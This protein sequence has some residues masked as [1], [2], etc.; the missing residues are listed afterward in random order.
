[1][2]KNDKDK[3]I[4]KSVFENNDALLKLIRALFMGL[5]L[6]PAEQKIIKDTFGGKTE[7]LEAMRRKFKPDLDRDASI[8]EIIHDWAGAENNVYGKHPDEIRQFISYKLLTLDMMEKALKLLENPEQASITEFLEPQSLE[9]DPLQVHLLA[10]VQY[11][12]HVEMQLTFIKILCMKE[13][14]AK[15]MMKR[16]EQ[17]SSK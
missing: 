4:L 10:Y 8:G 3:E 9:K 17:N 7:L 15:A 16:L 11:I 13:E 5:S 14:D 6:T 2:N 1:M 12:K